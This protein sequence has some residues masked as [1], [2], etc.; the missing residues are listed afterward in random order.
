[1]R[2]LVARV[3]AEIERCRQAVPHL[4]EQIAHSQ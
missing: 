4:L 2:P 1:V 3:R